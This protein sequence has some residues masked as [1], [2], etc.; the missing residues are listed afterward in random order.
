MTKEAP[1]FYDDDDGDLAAV[2]M[3][4]IILVD[5]E[6]KSVYAIDG[7]TGEQRNAVNLVAH[8]RALA[9]RPDGEHIAIATDNG[10]LI[11]DASLKVMHSLATHST[12][13]VAYSSDGL[14]I[15]AGEASGAF[16]V[17]LYST[18]SPL[19]DHIADGTGHHDAVRGLSY[20]PSSRR[21]VSGSKDHTAIVWAVPSM[22]ALH[23]LTGHK[24]S[25]RA[26]A[27]ISETIVATGGHDKL[28]CVWDTVTA[29]CMHELKLHADMVNVLVLSAD[30]NS[31]ISGGDDHTIKLTDTRTYA[32][33]ASI[34]CPGSISSIC[35][36]EG[37]QLVV[38][39]SKHQVVIVDANT[40]IIVNKLEHSPKFT[41]PLGVAY[42]VNSGFSSK[43]LEK[44]TSEVSIADMLGRADRIQ[45]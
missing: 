24:Q 6:S 32:C 12:H 14:Y 7:A 37:N 13:A 30:G 26:V 11:L 18:S 31:L 29:K 45:L 3:S 2:V 16:S 33:K 22:A 42:I 17:R 20:S 40:G 25:I 39:V 5:D 27:Y 23:S 44:R 15:A 34:K 19:Y 28:V 41:D 1:L 9:V 38:G 43:P 4:S 10:T 35:L 21:V 8:T 36:G